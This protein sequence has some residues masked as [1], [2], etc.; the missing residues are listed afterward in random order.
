M[1]WRR[2]RRPELER[3]AFGDV[4]YIGMRQIA[5]RLRCE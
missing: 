3:L 5:E 1:D 2:I 4:E